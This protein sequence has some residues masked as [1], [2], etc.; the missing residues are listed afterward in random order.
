MK[1]KPILFN[2][3]MVRAIMDGR[4]TQTRRVIKPQPVYIESSSRWR[5]A[6]TGAVTAS[7]EWY[8]YMSSLDHCPYGKPGDL[9]WVR[10]TWALDAG[11]DGVKPSDISSYWGGIYYRANGDKPAGK[12]RPSIFMPRWASRLTLRVKSVKA[13]RLQGIS[14]GDCLAEGI[15]PRD[16]AALGHVDARPLLRQLW[17]NINAKRGY[18]WD[19]N[20]WVWVIE[21]EAVDNAVLRS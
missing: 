20:P 17:D 14:D 21:F 9:L 18:G 15:S 16:V 3:E 5:W 8:E 7:R 6:K 1:E 13:E 19:A 2:S 11:F 4:K 10:E 12:W